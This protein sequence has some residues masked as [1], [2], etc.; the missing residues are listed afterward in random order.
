MALA[1]MTMMRGSGVQP[2][3]PRVQCT[4]QLLRARFTN[5]PGGVD[6]TFRAARD[7]A[8]DW[9]ISKFPWI[10]END[11]AM[12]GRSFR[13]SD[14]APGQNVEAVAIEDEGLWTIR[15]EHPDVGLG[16]DAPAVAGRT[17][18][19]HLSLQRRDNDV[20]LGV[21]I[22]CASV[23][24]SDEPA[25]NVRPGVVRHWLNDIGI[26]DV[27]P[28]I[29]T[30]WH[31][32]DDELSAFKT[33]LEDPARELPVVVMT[34]PDGDHR[35]YLPNWS[36]DERKVS[37]RLH[38][39]AHVVL[40]PRH[41]TRRW[42]D[43]VGKEWSVFNGAV[44]TY[45]PGLSFENQSVWSHPLDLPDDILRSSLGDLKCEQ[46]YQE[47]LVERLREFPPP[48]GAHLDRTRVFVPEA[49]TQ[50]AARASQRASEMIAQAKANL[51]S[52]SEEAKL[53]QEQME[54][55][56]GAQEEELR[57]L[58]QELEE[59]RQEAREY[60]VEWTRA[61]DSAKEWEQ[62]VKGMQWQVLALQ[63]QLREKT[64]ASSDDQILPPAEYDEIAD[65]V[66]KHFAGRLRLHPRTRRGLKGAVYEDV[67][68]VGRALMLLANEYW[69]MRMHG[70]EEGAK[71]SFEDKCTSLGLSLSGSIT[72]HRA[73]EEGDQY[74][75]EWPQG[76]GK[77]AFL[78]QHL[79]KGT[80]K[81]DRYCL[82]IY[83]F[84]SD[85]DACVVVGWL[86]SHLDNRMT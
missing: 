66:L 61:N 85:D 15:A 86:P 60:E 84:W 19:N 72:K 4:Y 35:Q 10:K 23:R 56:R 18:V 1:G 79:R 38:G 17:W 9:L 37:K 27:R 30:P 42:T 31:L 43:E 81:D 36:V 62:Q 53:L 25:R 24:F 76:S 78:E 73:G 83:F 80:T 47:I 70:G 82:G 5:L 65:W 52:N 44:R 20:L 14:E 58:H 57:A 50:A 29:S 41:L 75:V 6:D 46:A 59:A 40:M 55:M 12:A 77:K 22:I 69:Q 39:H 8:M 45:M 11:E 26:V 63:E 2:G 48:P 51:Q 33:L 28:L 16:E 67:E 54:K 34:N 49:R 64:G 21:R 68:L 74:F 7:I 32:R 71:R 3:R 13:I